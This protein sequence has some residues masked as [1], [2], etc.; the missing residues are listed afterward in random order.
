[1]RCLAIGFFIVATGAICFAQDSTPSP[2][3]S[4]SD[5]LIRADD[6]RA[7]QAHAEIQALIFHMTER[8]NAHD[9]AGFMEGL[10]KSKD[11]LLVVD[12]E[13]VR[14]WTEVYAAYQRGYPDPNAMGTLVSDHLETQLV[15]PDVAL[16]FNRWTAHLKGG[17]V[18]GTSTMVAHKFS[19]GWKIISD[20][21]TTLEP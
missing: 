17:R 4:H 20:H 10:W 9:L 7:I 13:E 5:E 3:I 1:M 8:W 19:D 14:G 21:S 12:A 2:L 18:L 6:P 11:F 15:S 16:V